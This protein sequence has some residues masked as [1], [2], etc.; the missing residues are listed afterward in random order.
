MAD[1]V[2]FQDD[3]VATPA[4]G[5]IVETQDQGG[6]VQRQVV[7]VEPGTDPIAVSGS[8]SATA[9]PIGV[10]LTDGS[11]DITTGGTSEQ[12]F[13]SNADRCLLTVQ[14]VSDA[15]MWVDFGTAAVADQPSLFLPAG[16]A[17]LC[18]ESGVVPTESVN[19]ICSTTGKP[20]TAKEATLP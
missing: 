14:N 6:G 5:V 16:G 18:F 8:I 3:A 10:T 11:G 7:Q 19:I 13:A 17:A 9:T 2:T 12:V 4:D 15:D 1:N 20:Y